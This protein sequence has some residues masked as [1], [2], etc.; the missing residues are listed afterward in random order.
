MASR[1][2][3]DDSLPE[4]CRTLEHGPNLILQS[5]PGTGKTTRVPLVLLALDAVRSGRILMLEPR[6]VAAR[7]AA[8]HMASLLGEKTGFTVGYHVR[9]DHCAGDQTRIEVVTEGILTARLQGDPGLEGISMVIFDEFHERSLNTDLGLA[10]CLEIQEVIRPELRLLVMSATMDPE[11]LSELMNGAPI[12]R[13]EGRAWPVDTRYYP[14]RIPWNPGRP[15]ETRSLEDTAV[16]V[17]RDCLDTEDGDI[18]VFLPGRREIRRMKSRIRE[19]L[20]QMKRNDVRVLPFHSGVSP[21]DQDRV[22]RKDTTGRRKVILSTAIAE[23]AVTIDG[24]SIVIDWGLMRRSRFYPGQGLD[25]LET[26]PAPL[27]CVNQRRGRAGRTGPGICCRLWPRSHNGQRHP[28]PVPQIMIADLCDLALQLACWGIQDSGTLKWLD[29]PPAGHL[30]QARDILFR[31]GA[32]ADG[33]VTDHGRILAGMGTHPRLAHMIARAQIQGLGWTACILTA[34]LENGGMPVSHTGGGRQTD[35]SVLV[36]RMDPSRASRRGSLHGSDS[37]SSGVWGKIRDPARHLA[38]ALGIRPG[39]VSADQTGALLARAFPERIAMARKSRRGQFV[40]ASGRGI[41]MDSED[42]L[43]GEK[44]IVAAHLDGDGRNAR[45][46]LAAPY[47]VDTLMS[48][49]SNDLETREIVT[50]DAPSGSVTALEMTCYGQL[51]LSRNPL[52]HPDAETVRTTLIHG[53]QEGGIGVLP[54]SSGLR[55]WLARAVFMK[56]SGGYPDLPAVDDRSL[57]ADLDIWLGPYL[58]GI[59]RLK[60][61]TP[62]RFETALKNRFSWEEQALIH[63][64]APTHIQVPSG[65]RLPLTYPLNRSD[66]AEV[67]VETVAAPILPVRLQEMFGCDTTPAVCG[68]RVP[69]V[70]HLLSPAGRPVQVTRDLKHFWQAGYSEVKKELKGRYPRHYWPDDPMGAVP[71]HRAK[72][73]KKKR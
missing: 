35:L 67:P 23:S 20:D 48:D 54:W 10:L 32:L 17:I 34:L 31:I 36:A 6:R 38:G 51:I 13:A 37:L 63:R 47:D 71:T 66:A 50:W 45:V 5:P 11:P 40:M 27:A 18:L 56:A 43:A 19:M 49:F 68:G 22:I 73:R 26:V 4:L 2:P 39:K 44:M 8:R 62:S 42:P 58:D 14:P 30:S 69:V 53:I 46:F 65:S 24:V 25:R 57:I 29:P 55:S 1:L 59:S 28:W 52:A 3:I 64:E 41:R 72:P 60:Q 21:R 70:L 12:L 9:M 33:G 61:I 15:K 7:S 16:R